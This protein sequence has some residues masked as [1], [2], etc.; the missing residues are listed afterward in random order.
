M[1]DT[2][3]KFPPSKRCFTKE[4]LKQIKICTNKIHNIFDDENPFISDETKK[5]DVE[6]LLMTL[7]KKLY[8]INEE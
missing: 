3:I 7:V 5:D 4:E 8:E 6:A 1:S 2:I